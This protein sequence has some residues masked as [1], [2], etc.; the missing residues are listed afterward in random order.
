MEEAADILKTGVT[1]IRT[2]IR[3]HFLPA[4]KLQNTRRGRLAARIS[5][6]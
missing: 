1:F 4:V 5:S 2:M 3:K 6:V